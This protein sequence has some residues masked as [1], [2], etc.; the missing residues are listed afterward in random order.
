MTFKIRHTINIIPERKGD[1][2]TTKRVANT[3]QLHQEEVA[4]AGDLNNII[5]PISYAICAQKQVKQW[6]MD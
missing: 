1:Y 6:K 5:D 4:E 3:T 2:R